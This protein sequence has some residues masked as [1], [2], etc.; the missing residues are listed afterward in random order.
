MRLR[1]SVL[2][3][4]LVF[5]AGCSADRPATMGPGVTGILADEAGGTLAYVSVMAC[6][7]DVC[8]YS[9][10]DADGRF[11]FLLDAPGEVLIKTGED[12]QASPRR[13]A[14]MVPVEI[15]GSEFLDIG[16]VRVPWLGSGA[17]LDS[18][19]A[20][21]A[22]LDVGD[23]LTLTLDPSDLDLLPGDTLTDIAAGRLAE[24]ALPRY[25]VL[26]A[27]E[28]VA[29]YALHPFAARSRRPV[30]V[31]VESDLPS[32]T[33]IVF[34]TIDEIDGG[35][36][37]AVP[38]VATGASLVTTQGGVTALTHLVITTPRD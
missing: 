11:T 34:R 30:G 33:P 21:Q 22:S 31:R 12:L 8:F 16:T 26:D 29:V 4:T 3:S 35:F 17:R 28:I 20:G 36:S 37:D 5:F 14:A 13:G 7:S 1:R 19:R 24:S 2:Y 10:S 23:G 27:E 15:H 6:R 9:D 38:G 25:A 18:E 32:G